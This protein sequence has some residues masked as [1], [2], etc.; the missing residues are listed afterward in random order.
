[1]A[2]VNRIRRLG[3]IVGAVLMVTFVAGCLN[4][5]EGQTK[6]TGSVI[7]KKTQKVGEFDPNAKQEVS[8]SKVR[9][10]DPYF[11]A[12]E[13]YRPMV[14]QIMKSHVAHALNLF[15][16]EHGRYPKDHA[17]FMAK[18]I[19]A[20]QIQLPVLPEGFQYMYDVQNH[21]LEIVKPLEDDAAKK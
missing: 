3:A 19:K 12:L 7:G 9:V 13:A 5:L 4:S 21:K 16:A 10:S 11:Y 17:E 15:N 20:N 6:K 2:T 14:E 8:D 1:M 18:I